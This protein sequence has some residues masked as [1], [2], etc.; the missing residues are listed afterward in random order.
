MFLIL[1]CTVLTFVAC[2]KPDRSEEADRVTDELKELM[3]KNPERALAMVDSAEQAGVY[4]AAD[5]N[6]L[7]VNIYWNTGQKRMAAFCGEQA[8]ADT[9]VKRKSKTYY[10]AL[11]VMVKWYEENGEYGK[12]N[13]MADE[14]LADVE[15]DTSQVALTMRSS[16][17]TRK[18]ECEI[19]TGHIDEAERLYLES[20]DLLMKGMTH[21]KGYWEIDPLFY[22]VLETSDFYLEH[23]KPEKALDLIAKGDT[24]LAR[25]EHSPEVPDKVLQFRRNNVTISQAM[26]Y[27]ANGQ[28]DKAEALYQKHRQTEGLSHTDI[29]VEGRY[30]AMTDRYDEAIRL[31]RQSDSIYRAA[32]GPLSSAF[33]NSRMSLE[34]D[35][36]QKAGRTAEALAL[37]NRI[38]QLTDSVRLQERRADM[39]Q[40]QEIKRQETEIIDKQH[41]LTVHRI[42]LVA[43]I[44]VC[45]LIA[46]LLWRSYK[47][48]KVLTAK[49]RK[50]FEEIE[51]R[52]QE[53]QQERASWFARDDLTAEQQ[54]FRRL[55]TLMDEQQPY[56]DETLNRDSLARLLGTNAKYLEQAI[57]QCS[58]GETPGDFITRYRLEHVARLLKTTD[59]PIAIIGELSGIPS[60][61]T[62]A[63]LFRNA[64]G[65]SPS[66]YRKI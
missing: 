41:S 49:N 3:F 2:T 25:L 23:G 42:I 54:L 4:A 58:K 45:L 51:Q 7:R 56:T 37:G 20:I 24:A 66:E 36:L 53:E 8:W 63:R 16:A 17:L 46:W 5:A 55:C 14:I 10:S 28:R 47:Y 1:L 30:L 44:L 29:F 62:L 19:H 15:K 40:Q 22:S 61:A 12:A 13:E 50:L 65:M 6:L 64:Y 35:A 31:Y 60:R 57:R 52:R 32:G 26:V 18:A 11:M 38:R 59:D 43:A 27:A 39:E 48:N 21:P 34:Y 33:I 9:G